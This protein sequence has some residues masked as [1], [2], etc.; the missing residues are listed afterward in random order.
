MLLLLLFLMLIFFVGVIVARSTWSR[1]DRRSGRHR[2]G[3]DCGG[4]CVVGREEQLLARVRVHEAH[5]AAR[6]IWKGVVLLCCKNAILQE[7][8]QKQVSN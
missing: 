7:I 8:F 4:S 5:N 1:I 2:R 6:K 3:H